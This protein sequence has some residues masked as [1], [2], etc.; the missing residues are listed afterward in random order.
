MLK[1]IF[2]PHY[3]IQNWGTHTRSLLQ[4]LVANKPNESTPSVEDP[5]TDQ[6]L[7]LVYYPIPVI[8]LVCQDINFSQEL[9]VI[10]FVS[11]QEI[12]CQ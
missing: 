10:V 7:P 12:S 2:I 9:S 4:R 5:F 11:A 3:E 1:G 6:G 8:E